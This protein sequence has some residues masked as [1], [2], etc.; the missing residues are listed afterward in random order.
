MNLTA[1]YRPW[2][3]LLGSDPVRKDNPTG[4]ERSRVLL[5]YAF[6]SG[7]SR[8]IQDTSGLGL[9]GAIDSNGVFHTLNGSGWT[10]SYEHWFSEKWLTNVTYS[11][12]SI[13]HTDAQPG[14]TYAGAKY[15]ANSL[16]WIPV[17]NMSIGIEYLYGER[18]N[19]DG[20]RGDAH[21]IQ[22]VFQYNF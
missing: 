22:T 9:D 10:A 5:Q 4:L 19:L 1:N 3:A 11:E 17:R 8:Y 14:D 16:W 18:R 15:L 6:G 12:V 2:A 7:I 20:Q 21:R 13:G